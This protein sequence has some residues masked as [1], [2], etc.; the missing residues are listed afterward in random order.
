M[1]IH[2]NIDGYLLKSLV[3]NTIIS[4]GR[5]KKNFKKILEAKKFMFSIRYVD[6]EHFEFEKFHTSVN[7]TFINIDCLG[8]WV[9]SC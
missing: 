2:L 1:K 3:I 7:K 6:T 8:R 5:V 4:W 9:Q